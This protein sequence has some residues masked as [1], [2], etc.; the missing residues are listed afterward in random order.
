[1]KRTEEFYI[2]GVPLHI[3]SPSESIITI[4]PLEKWS[5]MTDVE[6]QELSKK[7]IVVRQGVEENGIKFD[8]VGIM[9]VAGVFSRQISINGA[10]FSQ[11]FFFFSTF[12]LIMY[13]V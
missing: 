1:M 12:E 6:R 2:D 10:S 11:N 9:K 4:V 5:V 8:E 7:N 3:A 13:C